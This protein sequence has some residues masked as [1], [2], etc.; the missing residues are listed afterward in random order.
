M[1]YLLLLVILYTFLS[2]ASAQNS[3]KV[4]E[5]SDRFLPL[6]KEGMWLMK[7]Y[8]P[9]CGDCTRFSKVATEFGIKGFPT[10][11]FLKGDDVYSYDG[12][13]TREDIVAFA[14]RMMGP[15]VQHIHNDREMVEAKL[16][17][18][19]FVYAGSLETPLYQEFHMN[20]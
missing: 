4:L 9:W 10:I 5:L 1:K 20:A 13:R 12:D 16:N 18:L 14:R 7:F 6:R 3:G 17:S 8:A 15:P 19:F 11:M 2:D